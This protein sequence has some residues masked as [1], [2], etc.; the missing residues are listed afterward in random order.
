MRK[1]LVLSLAALCVLA[2]AVSAIA[3]EP[4]FYSKDQSITWDRQKVGKDGIGTLFGKYPFNRNNAPKDF[5]IREIG[6]MT[7]KP[8][9][10]IGMHKH[11]VNEDAYIIIS[12]EGTFLDSDGKE[13][14]VK[15][16]DTTIA[17]IGQSHAL[18]NT[19]KVDLIFLDVVAER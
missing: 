12:G 1:I 14:K 10:T 3:A 8:G 15:A 6:W 2:F 17:R 7:L 4:Q 16:G 13:T 9:D 11:E 5:I 19:G 18:Y